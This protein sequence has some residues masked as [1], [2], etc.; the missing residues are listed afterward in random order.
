MSKLNK[1]QKV[2]KE[3][4]DK[5]K[6]YSLKEAISILKSIAPVKFDE[7]VEISFNLGVDPKQSDQMV[8]GTITLPRGTGKK[9]RIIAFC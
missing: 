8:R 2:L 1:R 9:L 5:N 4:V 6:A 3:Q 7:T